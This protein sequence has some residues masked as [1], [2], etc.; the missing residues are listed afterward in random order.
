ML[1]SRQLPSS[2]HSSKIRMEK[3]WIKVHIKQAQGVR[4]NLSSLKNVM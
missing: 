4:A 2:Q 3:V 1:T